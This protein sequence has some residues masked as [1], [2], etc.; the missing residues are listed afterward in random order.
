VVVADVLPNPPLHLLT[1]S[2]AS[3]AELRAL[4][5][6]YHTRLAAPDAPALGVV[7]AS[8]NTGF[9]HANHRLAVLAADSATAHA[10]LGAWLSDD[11]AA[12]AVWHAEVSP[13]RR[14]RVAWLFPGQG[15]QYPGMGRQLYHSL[16]TFR[17]ALD[18]CAA[19]LDDQLDYPLLDVLWGDATTQLDQ[20]EFTQPALFALE[21]ALA[22]V[23]LSWGVRP[24]A[25]V[26]H[27]VGEY[28][29]AC[30]AGVF[31]LEDGLRLVASRG[32]LMQRLVEPGAMAAVAL[33]AE[34]VAAL[35]PD[36]VVIA[37]RNSPRETVV[38]GRS[39]A[40]VALA[41][42]LRARGVRVDELAVSHAFHS[43]LLAP[44]VE[45][46]GAVA[47]DV[48]YH[49]PTAQLVSTVS[50]RSAGAELTQAGYWRDQVLAPVDFLGAMQTVAAQGCELFLDVGPHPLLLRLG[51]AGVPSRTMEWLPTLRRNRDDWATLLGSLGA[52]YAAGVSLDWAAVEQA[53][54]L[55][56]GNRLHGD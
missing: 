22:Q 54:G 49:T 24:A 25:V 46:F 17:A 14:P 42:S 1:L 35:V 30:V 7:C 10:R 23:W 20:T 37:A 50:G 38:A 3:A 8:A 45:A 34:T 31:S 53:Q 6:R 43:P 11:A 5:D 39:E 36:G 51:R 29:A 44:M 12:A 15:A 9:E 2:A 26:G 18:R 16:P 41:R 21:W 4:A 47:S 48:R 19:L 13:D 28:V 56:V 27:S 52:L 32:R 40:V 33:P 55:P